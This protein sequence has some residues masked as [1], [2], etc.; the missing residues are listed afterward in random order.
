M[1]SFL[2][3]LKAGVFGS[4][5]LAASI[6]VF[7]ALVLLSFKGEVL[8]ALASST[9]LQCSSPP[10]ATQSCFNDLLVPGI[11]EY[12]FVRTLI[13]AIFFSVSIG[14]YFD[15]IPGVTYTRRAVLASFVMLIVMLFLG[16]Y[17]IVADALEE[18]LMVS[19]ELVAVTVF[20]F[21]YASLYRRFT[22]EVE[23]QSQKPGL[24]ILVDRRDLTGKKRTFTTNSSHRVEAL[25]DGK[26]FKGWLV[27]GGVS[28]ENAK[29]P[30]TK[31]R[32]VGDGLLKAS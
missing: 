9:S 23:F 5:Y 12:D 30:K 13:V 32:V 26:Q 6:S 10:A 8:S 24:K 14:M 20:A 22:R 31:V 1:G 7:N 28:V 18:V 3:G 19:F 29:D 11:P 16:L 2:G 15:Y 27:S 21:I 17:G 4:I 25:S